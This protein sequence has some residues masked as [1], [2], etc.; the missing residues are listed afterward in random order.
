MCI[1]LS[2]TGGYHDALHVRVRGR[3]V[4]SAMLLP[5]ILLDVGCLVSI[6]V[7]GPS[8]LVHRA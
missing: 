8:G 1:V 2:T 3:S 6:S 5:G 4:R 7:L